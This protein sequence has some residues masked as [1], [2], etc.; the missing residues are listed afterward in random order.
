MPSAANAQSSAFI[1]VFRIVFIYPARVRSLSRVT[2]H[3]NGQRWS[4]CV[5]RKLPETTG[6]ACF[7]QEV[8]FAYDRARGMKNHRGRKEKREKERLKI[9]K[10]DEKNPAGKQAPSAQQAALTRIG[11]YRA[12]S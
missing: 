5:L 12:R 7:R 6:G 8:S 4:Q 3:P 1:R 11:R 2:S 9:E 10:E